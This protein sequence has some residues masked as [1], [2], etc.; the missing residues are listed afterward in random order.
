VTSAALAGATVYMI[1]DG[2]VRGALFLAVGLVMHQ[3]GHGDELRVYGRGRA[4][5]TAGVVIAVGAITTAAIPPFG[6]FLARSLIAQAAVGAWGPIISVVLV[7]SGALAGG[8]LLRAFARIFLGIGDREDPLLVASPAGEDEDESEERS[9]RLGACLRVPALVLLVAGLGLAFA[10][11]IADRAAQYAAQA[12]DARAVALQTL[13]GVKAAPKPAVTQHVSAPSV[14][15]GI[16]SG[17]LAVAVA[18]FGLYRRRLRM[19]G[20]GL[21]APVVAGLK[22]VHDGVPGEYVAWLTFGT[23]AIGAALALLVR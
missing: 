22:A 18:A 23:A 21:A 15:A 2:L 4:I 3:C 19:P 6:P 11:G 8:A 13:H 10:P 17:L 9:A 5:P 14:V 7:L 16:L 1:A 20:G 12:T